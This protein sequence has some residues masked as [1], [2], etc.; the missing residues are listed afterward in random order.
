LRRLSIVFLAQLA[1]RSEL[2]LSVLDEESATG[3]E[4]S[5]MLI[6]PAR[7]WPGAPRLG[8]IGREIIPDS[9]RRGR[10]ID[11]FLKA[12]DSCAAVK[13]AEGVWSVFD[14]WIVIGLAL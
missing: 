9:G 1:R 10:I 6:V 8:K 3:D 7:Q 11:M 12:R 5:K 14:N 4:P 2:I 13:R